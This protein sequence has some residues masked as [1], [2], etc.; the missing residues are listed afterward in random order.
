MEVL[1][2]QNP[3]DADSIKWRQVATQDTLR[4]RREERLIGTVP[5]TDFLF[6]VFPVREINKAGETA[7]GK[8][9]KPFAAAYVDRS[10]LSGSQTIGRG[11]DVEACK[12]I[13]RQWLK[14]WV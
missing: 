12:D 2:Y 7:T 13:C 1:T 5:D 11:D 14:M 4:N 9:D 6:I 10:L 8:P 3:E